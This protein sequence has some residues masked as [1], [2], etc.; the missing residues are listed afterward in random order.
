MSKRLGSTNGIILTC[1]NVKIKTHLASTCLPS[2]HRE[3]SDRKPNR[4]EEA[5]T[6]TTDV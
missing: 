3:I 2:K 5:V 6:E 1:A 4:L